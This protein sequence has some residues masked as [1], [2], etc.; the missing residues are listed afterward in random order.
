MQIRKMGCEIAPK[1]GLSHYRKEV[2]SFRAGSG[3]KPLNGHY[4]INIRPGSHDVRPD[5]EVRQALGAGSQSQTLL[6][7]SKRLI[8]SLT[9][10]RLREILKRMLKSNS[11]LALA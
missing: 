6:F 9:M 8:V 2:H 11:R 4:D 3:P 1:S 5:H 10:R 7:H